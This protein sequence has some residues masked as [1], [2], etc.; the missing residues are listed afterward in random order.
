MEMSYKRI[1]EQIISETKRVTE[2]RMEVE[3]SAPTQRTS[4]EEDEL[5]C[6]VKKFKESNGAR[7]FLQPRNLVSY[8]DILMGDILR[9]YE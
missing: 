4:E 6:K 2:E 1:F 8:K 5:H 9:A 3:F 7:S